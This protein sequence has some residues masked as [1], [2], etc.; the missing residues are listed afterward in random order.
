MLVSEG[1]TALK[2]FGF[3]DNDP[4]ISWLNEGMH[5]FEDAHDWPF[6]QLVTTVAT[7]IGDSTL[8]LPG[9]LHKVQSIRD[10]TSKNKLDYIT[11]SEFERTISDPT[12]RGQPLQYTVTGTE[13]VQFF[14]VTDL[15]RSFRVVYQFELTDMVLAP[16]AAMPGPTRIHYPI[17]QGAAMIALQAENEEDRAVTAKTEFE[18]AIDRLWTKY[19]TQEM[20]EPQQVTDVMGYGSI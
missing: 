4:I 3:D 14:P 20:D 12:V 15:A 13:T 1:R 9:P 5:Q 16:D 7:A 8:V 2:R 18:A 17:V 6:L 11:V 10:V 19:S